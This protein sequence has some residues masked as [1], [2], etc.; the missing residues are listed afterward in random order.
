M[1]RIPQSPVARSAGLAGLLLAASAGSGHA[2]DQIR[3]L[4]EVAMPDRTIMAIRFDHASGLAS[5]VVVDAESGK[6]LQ[7]QT[8][9]GRPQS[10]RQ[11]FQDAIWIVGGDPVL[12]RLIAG[13]AIVE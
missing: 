13:G 7:Q 9:A 8:Y 5:R 1:A 12:G 11:E 4:R 3:I 10:S 6:I 2:D